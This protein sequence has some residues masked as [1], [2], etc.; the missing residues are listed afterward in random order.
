MLRPILVVLLLF[1]ISCGSENEKKGSVVSNSVVNEK[2]N[3]A[4]EITFSKTSHDF[5][6]ISEGEVV[7]TN[8]SFVNTG[9]S[10]L[11]IL[12][13]SASC[14]CTVPKWSKEPIPPGEKGT[15]EVIFDSSGREGRQN[16]SISVRTNAGDQNVVLFITAEVEAEK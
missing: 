6:R 16:K 8:F 13:A 4:P 10:N 7:G 9:K 11:I 3:K 14:G 12:D 15:L 1:I 5:G 2:E